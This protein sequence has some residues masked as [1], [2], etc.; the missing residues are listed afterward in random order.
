M[1]AEVVGV[2]GVGSW[3]G[4]GDFGGVEIG[5]DTEDFLIKKSLLKWIGIKN[6]IESSPSILHKNSFYKWIGA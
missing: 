1:S 5:W 6:K 2:R 3:E 4:T